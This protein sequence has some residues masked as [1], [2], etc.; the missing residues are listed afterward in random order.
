MEKFCMLTA[1]EL[2]HSEKLSQNFRNS[3]DLALSNIGHA[4]NITPSDTRLVHT[5][6]Q[7]GKSWQS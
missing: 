2:E 1:W 4:D 5:Q 6:Q 7:R 3:P